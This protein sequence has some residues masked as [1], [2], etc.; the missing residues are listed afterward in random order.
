LVCGGISFYPMHDLGL[1]EVQRPARVCVCKGS[2]VLPCLLSCCCW[3]RRPP[4]VRRSRLRAAPPP[5]ACPP[6]SPSP[7]QPGPTIC[8][9]KHK[10]ALIANRLHTHTHPPKRLAHPRS[11]IPL[12]LTLTSR[13]TQ[14]HP[15]SPRSTGF[16]AIYGVVSQPEKK[17]IF[18]AGPEAELAP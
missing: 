3:P 13:A 11:P 17:A 4:A 1:K 8:L 16:C 7:E 15:T 5:D 12:L 14:A 10:H 9:H 2:S 18:K 6:E